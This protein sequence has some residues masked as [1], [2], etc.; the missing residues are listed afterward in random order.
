[1]NF[2]WKTNLEKYALTNMLITNIFFIERNK[3]TY[4]FYEIN[5]LLLV[6]RRCPPHLW[7]TEIK[8]KNVRQELCCIYCL[9]SFHHRNLFFWNIFNNLFERLRKPVI[10]VLQ[11]TYTEIFNYSTRSLLKNVFL[12]FF[13]KFE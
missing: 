2:P 5:T 10:S 4:H 1:M 9:A 3:A 13:G 12:F 6:E 8:I 11:K 7:S